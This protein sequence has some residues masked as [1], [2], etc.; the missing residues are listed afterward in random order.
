MDHEPLDD[1]IRILD[2]ERFY[3]A[4]WLDRPT[5]ARAE[6]VRF[7]SDDDGWEMH[8]DT[9]VGRFVV[10]VHGCAWDL[11]DAVR[12]LQAWRAEGE[13][14]RATAVRVTEDDLDAYE[15]GDP[16]RVSLQHELDRQRSAL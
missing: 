3:S 15:L 9:D 7:V 8:V 11:C 4:A 12:P 5:R 1:G 6:T 16:K 2:G 13:H 14:A 10:N